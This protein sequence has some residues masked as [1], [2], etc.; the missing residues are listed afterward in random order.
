MVPVCNASVDDDLDE[1]ECA[2]QAA[3][4]TCRFGF[5]K[6]AVSLN[7]MPPGMQ[8]LLPRSDV[9][10]RKDVQLLEQGQ[11]EQVCSCQLRMFPARRQGALWK[12]CSLWKTSLQ[13]DPQTDQLTSEARDS[14]KLAGR[15]VSPSW[16]VSSVS[17][18]HTGWGECTRCVPLKGSAMHENGCGHGCRLRRSGGG[19]CSG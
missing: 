3:A 12:L 9:R 5:S 18:G 16:Q 1:L 15:P 6:W 10:W 4:A 11:Y 7:S 2:T 19:Y 8:K 14:V 13:E 17:Q